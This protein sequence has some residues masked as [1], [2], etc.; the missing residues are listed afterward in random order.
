M[1][2]APVGEKDNVDGSCPFRDVIDGKIAP[3]RKP[4]HADELEGATERNYG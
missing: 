4:N 1:P 2:G 3:A